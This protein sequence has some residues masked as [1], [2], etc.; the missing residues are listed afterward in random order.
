LSVQARP[1]LAAGAL[2]L[3]WCCALLVGAERPPDAAAQV[4]TQADIIGTWQG[5]STCVDKVTFPACHDEEV[6]YEVRPTAQSPD[7]VT[8]RADKVVN[9]SREFMGEL[10]FG[11]GP[12]G[13][14]SSEFESPRVRVRWTIR[15]EGTRMSGALIDVAS[16]RQVRAV[17]LQ[18]LPA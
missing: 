12:G 14:W 18:R 13:E 11:R 9:G 4:G 2:R 8:L 1:R 17:A 5:T 3:A 15:V 16:G 10:V 6:I 7:S